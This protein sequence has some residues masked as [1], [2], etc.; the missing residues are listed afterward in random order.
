[1]LDEE[2]IKQQAREILD[3]FAR[4]LQGIHTEES[5]AE[6]E[7]SSREEGKEKAEI[8]REIMFS[9]APKTK[10]NCIEAEKGSWVS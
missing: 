5:R 2:K 3:K 10:N 8:D 7:E 9:N 4:A 1:M 6:R